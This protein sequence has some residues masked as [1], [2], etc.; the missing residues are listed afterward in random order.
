MR[1]YL[2]AAAGI[3][4]ALALAS[5]SLPADARQ[6]EQRDLFVDL[7]P[8]VQDMPRYRYLITAM[9]HLPE[10]EQ[11]FARQMLAFAED[12]LG[13]Y[14]EAVRDFP[15][16]NRPPGQLALP[17]TADWQATD[18]V[19]TI[20]E[21]AAGRRI[22]MVNEAHHDAHTRELTLALLPR[23]RAIGFTHFAAEALSEKDAELM[24]RGYPIISSG[25]EYLHEPLYG[26]IVR[27]AIRL[28]YVIVPY[29]SSG[30][31]PQAREDGQARHLY[32]RVLAKDP[33]AR[34]F[35]HA[36]YA[37][38]DKQPG[39]LGPTRPMAMELS[40]LS[41]I[42]PLS[43]DQTDIREDSPLS[44]AEA[45]QQ[46]KHALER[47]ETLPQPRLAPA[48]KGPGDTAEKPM[49]DAYHQ[50]IATFPSPGAI[51]L[52]HIDTNAPWS[53]RPGVYD[54][55][56]ILPPANP[57]YSSYMQGPIV[58]SIDGRR[59]PVLPPASGGKRPDWLTLGGQRVAVP[60]DT[61]MCAQKTPCLVEA[62]YASE[63]DDAV[64][65]DR[66]LFLQRDKANVLYLRPGNYRLRSV[67]VNNRTVKEQ[68]IE[69]PADSH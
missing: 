34:L 17:R 18:A 25:S 15:L 27:E 41:G 67:D 26:D 42:E 59:Y 4:I 22:V 2:V 69:V 14:S 30:A 57:V 7:Q 60:I 11:L 37:H 39:R 32:E 5:T 61:A 23:L 3:S 63:S 53:A 68:P 40:K 45:Y 55:N 43:I 21:L 13:L 66:Y 48:G 16:R 47:F 28:G 9:P 46:F 33:K 36:G 1:Q 54:L 12:E 64:A 24:Q 58:L 29:E 8:L 49:M 31:T 56:V 38:I 50:I 19:D 20:A 65:A 44:E 6:K 10:T 51:V 52:R 62:H 35:I